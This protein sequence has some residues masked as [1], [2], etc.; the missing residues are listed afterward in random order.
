MWPH[1]LP[2]D[3]ATLDVAFGQVNIADRQVKGPS[4]NRKNMVTCHMMVVKCHA[5]ARLPHDVVI[6]HTGT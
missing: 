4:C 5:E 2:Q 3:V 1:Q 6:C